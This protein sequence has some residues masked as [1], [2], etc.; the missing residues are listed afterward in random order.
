LRASARDGRGLVRA[1]NTQPALVLRC[2][3]SDEA[4]LAKIRLTIEA[5]VEAVVEAARR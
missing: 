5:V 4:A 3:G 2:E 1:S